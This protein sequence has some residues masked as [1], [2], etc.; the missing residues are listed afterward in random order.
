VGD[1]EY[2]PDGTYASY[3]TPNMTEAVMDT[4][5]SFIYIPKSAWSKFYNAIIKE[6]PAA[7]A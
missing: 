7:Y 3:A 2:F 5:T 1:V 6:V 4:G